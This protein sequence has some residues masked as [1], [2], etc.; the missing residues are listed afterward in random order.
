MPEH[1]LQLT[2]G[3]TAAL[4]IPDDGMY[5]STKFVLLLGGFG[6]TTKDYRNLLHPIQQKAFKRWASCLIP[7]DRTD[8]LGKFTYVPTIAEQQSI[9][10]DV[11]LQLRTTYSVEKLAIVAMSMSNIPVL[12]ELD[13]INRFGG[14]LETICKGDTYFISLSPPFYDEWLP[15]FVNRR[16]RS[17]YHYYGGKKEQGYPSGEDTA[18]Y[19]PRSDGSTTVVKRKFMADLTNIH[20]VPALR[21]LA[22]SKLQRL[23]VYSPQDTVVR[24]PHFWLENLYG[25][26]LW[27]VAG[28]HEFAGHVK[29]VAKV[30]G[31]IV[32]GLPLEY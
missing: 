23:V 13:Y 20:I 24:I 29:E 14:G 16:I 31:N 26:V 28:G 17:M 22:E 21:R 4:N 19:L 30:V 8:P 32:Q 1:F 7:L 10:R 2:G 5:A 18:C 25:N 27:P 3:Y 11:V 9:I 12:L 6:A 15:D